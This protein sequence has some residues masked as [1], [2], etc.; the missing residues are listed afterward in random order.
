[1]QKM[2]IRLLTIS[3]FADRIANMKQGGVLLGLLWTLCIVQHGVFLLL[4]KSLYRYKKR[5][6]ECWKR[7]AKSS[8][9]M[10]AYSI[11]FLSYI[12]PL[13]DKATAEKAGGLVLF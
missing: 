5:P 2:H 13:Q 12:F 11:I 7:A 1:M 4:L 9:N 6:G 10:I 8:H 3:C